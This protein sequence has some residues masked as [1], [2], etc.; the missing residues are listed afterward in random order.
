M[1]SLSDSG[2][3]CLRAYT[4]HSNGGWMHACMRVCAECIC[5]RVCINEMRFVYSSS[6]YLCLFVCQ[7]E[8]TQHDN[9]VGVYVCEYVMNEYVYMCACACV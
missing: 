4:Q 8:Y 7:R 9:G 6:M 3:I 1:M 5:V 2:Y